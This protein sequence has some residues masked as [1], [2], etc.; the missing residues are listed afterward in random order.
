VK[1]RESFA[2]RSR[3]LASETAAK[4]AS[5]LKSQFLANMSH[6][7]RCVLYLGCAYLGANLGV[8]RTP[9]AGVIGLSELL[10]DTHLNE[11]QRGIAENIQRS[12]DALLTWVFIDGCMRVIFTYWGLFQLGLLMIFLTFR[13]SIKSDDVGLSNLEQRLNW[14]SSML[15]TFRYPLVWY[16]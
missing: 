14:A 1:L 13:V 3:L 4:E 15:I 6:E 2:E 8:D 12:A 10:C 16:F 5:R 9:I 11:E 7:I